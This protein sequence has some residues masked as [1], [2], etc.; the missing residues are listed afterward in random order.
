[1]AQSHAVKLGHST[2]LVCD[3]EFSN[4]YSSGLLTYSEQELP[5]TSEALRTMIVD[6]MTDRTQT[7]NWYIGYI[8]G[9][10]RGMHEGVYPQREDPTAP[11]VHLDTLTLHLNRWRF[12][13]GYY[14]GQ[15]MYEARHYEHPAMNVL[16]AHELLSSIAHYDPEARSYYFDARELAAL[17]D[18][19]GQFLGY[20]CAACCKQSAQQGRHQS[21]E[22]VV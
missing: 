6:A 9:A 19:L 1:M 16:T 8:A 12:R 2:I 4:G 21:A 17:E 3:D 15:G 20:F 13:D 22:S 7:E 14:T 11:F 5:F 18:I 10:I